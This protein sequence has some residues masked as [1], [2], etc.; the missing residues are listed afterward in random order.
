[1]QTRWQSILE[2]FLN[3]LTGYIISVIAQLVIFPLYGLH[4]SLNDNMQ[5]VALFTAISIVRSYF[6]RRLFNHLH[7]PRA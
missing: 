3:T 1:M 7:H 4:A 2:T 5:I 6:W